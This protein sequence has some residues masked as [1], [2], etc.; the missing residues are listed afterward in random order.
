MSKVSLIVSHPTGNAN[1]R[2]AL[3]GFVAS[4]ILKEFHTTVACFNDDLII[5]LGKGPLK[6]F[7]RRIYPDNLKPFTRSH[8]FKELGRMLA[9]KSGFKNLVAHE[10]GAF[11]VDAVYHHLDK[12]VAARILELKQQNVSAVYAYEDGALESF[13]AASQIRICKLYDQPIGYW[14][15]ARHYLEKEREARPE[16]AMTM[17][18]FNDSKEKLERK[19][20][21]IQLADHIFA[22]SSFTASTLQYYPGM[23][24]EIS[25]IPYGFPDIAKEKIYISLKDRPLEVLFVGGLSQ[26]K[27][28]ANVFEAA[29]KLGKSINLTIVGAKSGAECPALDKALKTCTWIQ[30]LP[31]HEILELMRRSDVLVFP[32][33][34][35][36]FG[37]VITE[38]MSQGIPVITTNRTAGPDVITDGEN[39]LIIEAGSTEALIQSL[40]SLIDQPDRIE[41][42]GRNARHTASLRPWS[43]YGSELSDA[44]IALHKLKLQNQ[45]VNV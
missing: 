3:Q 31:H 30:G 19:D 21:E 34:F 35:E 14:R 4:D 16:W 20:E 44:I 43:V 17:L 7:K 27:G 33:L 32:S 6:E 12:K 45:N 18:G 25:V 40:Q 11:S 13:K 41:K 5:K 8:P 26:R 28:I 39:G 23:L 42:M 38:A 37:L 29:E 1:L 9:L 15:A 2:A 36:G 10:S 24:N 22:A